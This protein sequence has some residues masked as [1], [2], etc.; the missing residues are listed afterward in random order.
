LSAIF[1]KKLLRSLFEKTKKG[2]CK[3]R[4]SC[5]KKLKVTESFGTNFQN[6]TKSI[7]KPKLG[8]EI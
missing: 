4:D 7:E 3:K 6:L 2:F 5:V 8:S 1:P